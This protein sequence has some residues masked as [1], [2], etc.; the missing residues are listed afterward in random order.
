MTKVW[1]NGELLDESQAR[2]SPFD[3]GLLLGD[4]I[5]ETMRVYGGRP[6]ALAG[7]LARLRRSCEQ[8]RIP[9]PEGIEGV[10][11]EVIG[12]NGIEEGQ[13][14]VTLTR[15]RGG[16]GASPRGAGPPTVLVTATPVHHPPEA[17]ERGLRLVTSTRRRIPDTSLPASIKSTNYLVHVLARIQAEEAG[18]DDALFVDEDGMVVE[19]TQANVF[20][21]L[22]GALVTPPLESGCLPGQTRA[23]VLALAHEAGLAPAERA[24]PAE[25]LLEAREVFL[26][27]SVLEVAP[28][29]ELDGVR[30]GDGRPGEITRKLHALYRQRAQA[31]AR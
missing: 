2:I 24:L 3:R 8:T 10:L 22:G 16:R 27:A 4:A 11:D 13:V 9:Y 6:H 12:A 30:I 19:A 5:F 17:Y 26:T 31:K 7:H 29:I 18:A 14:R 20:A 28:V 21:V 23:E 25:A 15:G 1:L